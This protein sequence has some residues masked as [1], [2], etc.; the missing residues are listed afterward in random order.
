[1]KDIAELRKEL[2]EEKAQHRNTRAR[3]VKAEAEH[4]KTLGHCK[5]EFDRAERM[6]AERDA[7]ASALGRGMNGLCRF[8]GSLHKCLCF[9]GATACKKCWLDYADEK[10][11]KY[12]EA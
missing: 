4:I 7:L 1:M 8:P 11:S 10:A 6:K 12:R 2:R 9:A 5:F 3:A